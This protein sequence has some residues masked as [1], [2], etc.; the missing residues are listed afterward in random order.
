MALILPSNKLFEHSHTFSGYAGGQPYLY[1]KTN[2]PVV[3]G[4]QH[5][6]VRL[7]AKC[8]KCGKE[9]YVA[10]I[11]TDAEGKLFETSLDKKNLKNDL[12]K[13]LNQKIS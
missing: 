8:D 4:I 3:D 6:H 1:Y 12:S 2:Q 11:H 10:S 13:R 7:Y 9:V 5:G